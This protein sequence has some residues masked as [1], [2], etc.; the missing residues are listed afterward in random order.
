M[1]ERVIIMA[2][3][4]CCGHFICTLLQTFHDPDMSLEVPDYGG[5]DHVAKIGSLTYKFF[6]EEKNYN[7]Y[8]E[9]KEAMDLIMNAFNNPEITYKPYQHNYEKEFHEI[10]VIHYLWQ[11]NINKFLSLP[12]TKIIFVSYN[13]SDYRRIAVNKTIKKM[14]MNTASKAS[15]SNLL[16]W[17]GFEDAVNELNSLDNIS[18][19]SESLVKS[20]IL[21]WEKYIALRSVHNS[22]NPDKNLII[23]NFND[24]YFDK[25]CI[26]KSLSEFTGLPINDSTKLLYNSYLA[27]QP[28][29]E[30]Y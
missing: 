20:L 3:G 25:D 19:A 27:N 7:I 26:M 14:S 2:E 1:K 13:Q 12:N 4:G 18:D 22:P 8:P 16:I 24:L 9:R 30:K 6:Q 5:M 28:N 17:A 10:H 11:E 23:L 15:Y 21:T 29:I